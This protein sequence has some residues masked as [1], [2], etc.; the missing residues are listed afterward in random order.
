MRK[1]SSKVIKTKRYASGG[2]VDGS[3]PSRM[4]MKALDKGERTIN[5]YAKATPLTLKQRRP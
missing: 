5:D 1:S 2:P 3:L 4:A